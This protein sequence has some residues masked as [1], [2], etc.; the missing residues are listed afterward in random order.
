MHSLFRH[1][2]SI[3]PSQCPG[4]HQPSQLS[5]LCD[6]CT[7]YLQPLHQPC[8]RCG[9]PNQ[10]GLQCGQC[11]RFPPR[12]DHA[13]I[14]WE[15]DFLSRYLIHQFKYHKN[16]AAAEQLAI[17]WLNT[18]SV[19]TKPKALIPVPMTLSKQLRR[20][21]NQAQW[22]AEHWG[23]ALSIPVF[24]AVVKTRNTQPL[25]GLGKRQ[26]KRVLRNAFRL[27]ET[28]PEHVAIVDDV[29]TSGATAG[30]LARILKKAGVQR[31]DLWTLARTPLY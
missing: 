10:L 2:L 24:N 29:F 12:W 4:C 19:D 3:I 6:V 30:E 8:P 31:V 18:T 28:P 16:F 11:L 20:Q 15:F 27:T 26:R 17:G 25:E 21:Y 1:L 5:A 7:S 23:E 14:A 13:K 22:L 9:E